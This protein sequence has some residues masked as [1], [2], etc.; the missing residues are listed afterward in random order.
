MDGSATGK[1]S[2]DG[3]AAHKTGSWV[4]NA[5]PPL[6]LRVDPCGLGATNTITRAEL[7][8]IHCSLRHAGPGDC[9]IATDSQ[10]SMYMIRNQL[11]APGKNARSSHGVLLAVTA[12]VLTSRAKA[13]HRTRIINIKSHTGVSGN[14]KADELADAARQPAS[15]Q[16]VVDLGNVAHQEDFWPVLVQEGSRQ[17]ASNLCSGVKCHLA[18]CARGLANRTQYEGFWERV[19]PELH[20]LSFIFWDTAGLGEACIREVWKGA[21]RPDLARGQGLPVPN[22]V[23]WHASPAQRLP[24]VRRGGQH[25]PHTQRLQAPAHGCTLHAAA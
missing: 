9:V 7:V 12:E 16:E 21:H 24:P 15:C 6:Q 18:P 13:G 11:S 17:L 22:A 1:T 14:E 4:Y 5:E 19:L 23:Q 10:A 2:E 25:H 8:A 3:T 20:A